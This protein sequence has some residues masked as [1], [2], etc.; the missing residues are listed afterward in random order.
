[1]V[2]PTFHRIVL[3]LAQ[4]AVTE[5]PLGDASTTTTQPATDKA[6]LLD[7]GLQQRMPRRLAQVATPSMPSPRDPFMFGESMKWISC[8]CM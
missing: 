2:L 5:S 1:M 8:H 6:A 3:P 7:V 4:D